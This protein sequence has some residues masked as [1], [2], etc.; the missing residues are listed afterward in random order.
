MDSNDGEE[1]WTLSR[2][3]D[4]YRQ[5]LEQL[6]REIDARRN[7]MVKLRRQ[8]SSGTYQICKLEGALFDP[9]RSHKTESGFEVWGTP[10]LARCGKMLE[11]VRSYGSTRWQPAGSGGPGRVEY[12]ER[13]VLV[14]GHSGGCIRR[15]CK[16]GPPGGPERVEGVWCN[17]EERCLLTCG[18][19]GKCQF[20]DSC[21]NSPEGS[22]TSCILMSE[23]DGECANDI[24][25]RSVK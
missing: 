24:V 17:D 12:S 4:T 15:C 8:I 9:Y 21:W 3:V 5:E 11:M 14:S 13:C 22:E 18:H 7:A 6:E 2:N 23:H 1:V 25:Y 20:P 16:H 19:A 10:S